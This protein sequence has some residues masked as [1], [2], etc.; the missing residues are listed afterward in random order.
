MISMKSGVNSFRI[1]GPALA[2]GSLIT[3]L[4]AC[5]GLLDVSNPGSVE[6]EDLDNPTLTQTLVNSAL[7]G[8]ECAYSS[9]VASTAILGQE[10]ID[11]SNWANLNGWG[12]RGLQLEEIIGSCPAGRNAS[13]LGAYAPLQQARYMAEDGARRIAAFPDE[14]VPD[15]PQTL[16]VLAGY[17]AYSTL[18][19][20]EGFCEMAIDQGPLMTRNEVFARAEGRF[21]EA[22]TYAEESGDS[23]GLLF[24]L[25][26]RARTRLN[27]GDFEGA[28]AD[29]DRIPEGFVRYAQFSAIDGTRENRIFNMNRANRFLS[30]EPREYGSV[31]LGGERDP[32]VLAVESGQVGHD[33]ITQHWFQEKY[34]AADAP[35]PIAS[36]EEAQLILAEARPDEAVAAINRLRG[37][38]GLPAYEPSGDH[39]GDV[40]EERRRQLFLEGHRLNDMLRHDL[41][42]PTGDNHKGQAWGPVTCMP[43]PNQERRNN[44]NIAQ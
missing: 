36:W 38:Q 2:C 35:I 15:K 14:T 40:L 20:G 25:A 37:S 16:G 10:M 7:G 18:L 41:P 39:I 32:R 11:A 17:A 44:P 8:F 3:A 22:I 9:Y 33:N 31:V 1:G 12:Q 19:L 5:D 23:D 34:V 13:S 21:N 24:A 28:A 30:V 6:A 43:L 27:L 42:F 29:A 26:G 4:I